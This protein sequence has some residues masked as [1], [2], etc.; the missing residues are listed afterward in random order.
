MAVPS[1]MAVLVGTLLI[2]AFTTAEAQTHPGSL[3]VREGVHGELGEALDRFATRFTPFG[4]AGQLLV[5]VDGRIVLHRA[6][7][8][9]DRAARRPMTT[10]TA[11]GIASASKQFTAAAVLRLAE[12]G[13]LSLDD[14][15]DRW[16]DDVP[17][18]KRGITI[19]QLLTHT[20]G[21]RVGLADDF[22][23]D[24]REAQIAAILG[25]PLSQDPGTGWRYANA[26]YILAAAVVEEASG[27]SY[28]GYLRRALFEPAGMTRTG[29]LHDPPDG[30]SDRGAAFARAYVGWEDMGAPG[31][32]PRNWR[33]MGSGDLVSTAA[34]L[35]RWER[36]L[37]AGR[38]LSAD[39]LD[40]YF[41]AQVEIGDRSGYAYGLFVEEGE[42]GTVIEHGGDTRIGY[43]AG[44]FRYLDHDAVLI[45]TSNSQLSPGRWMRHTLSADVERMILGQ[46]PKFTPPEAR[47]PTARDARRLTGSYALGNGGLLHV[48]HDGTYL[49][50]AAEGQRAAELLFARGTGEHAMAEAARKTRSLLRTLRERG[51]DDP[52]AYPRA[53]T[54]EG[55]PHL[56]GYA[57]EWGRLESA[58]GP[59]ERFDILG[60][61]PYRG[62]VRTTARLRF[63]DGEL[64]MTYFWSDRGRGRLHGTDTAVGARFPIS[65][66]LAAGE[67]DEVIVHDPWWETTLRAQVTAAGSPAG[68][69]VRL[70][71]R[72]GP[73]AVRR[74]LVDWTP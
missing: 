47:L 26:G 2:G 12:D 6:Y 57:A 23:A 11:V 49:W 20:A 4:F 64:T 46:E 58:L 21:L 40:R 38:I 72:H 43:N 54:T 5:A 39:G 32:W 60:S 30:S 15:I 61:L 48:V 55:L 13:R 35:W 24:T 7:G 36:A 31:E 70:D 56:D 1:A 50:M 42:N 33:T 68:A 10:E 37:L 28:E 9:A 8:M 29:F 22:A 51:P 62:D 45:V 44:F 59:Y 3:D 18:D 52:K 53:L 27:S 25:A 17:E 41:T 69:D 67:G 16:L 73:R 19:H 63:R 74:G 34:D 71:F 14:P 65:T 66:P